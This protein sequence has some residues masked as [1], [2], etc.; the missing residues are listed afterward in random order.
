MILRAFL[1]HGGYAATRDDK[2]NG[3]EQPFHIHRVAPIHQ[4]SLCRV[5]NGLDYV[6]KQRVGPNP[7]SLLCRL[8]SLARVARI[9]RVSK[10]DDPVLSMALFGV[11]ETGWIQHSPGHR[12][13]D[14]IRRNALAYQKLFHP[15]RSFSREF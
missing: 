13:Q 9:W 4:L 11:F 6:A 1:R 14:P 2:Q 12:Q 7:V 8:A 10:P 5:S 15:P 3:R